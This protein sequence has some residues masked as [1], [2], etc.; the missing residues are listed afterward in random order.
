MKTLKSSVS[1][2][3]PLLMLTFIAC[4]DNGGSSSGSGTGT[5]SL[6]L[7]DN[8][9]QGC[10]AVYVTIDDVQVH[11][12]GGWQSLK[13]TSPHKTHNLLELQNGVREELG[14]AELAEG[15]YTQMRL[16]IGDT[17]MMVIFLQITSLMKTMSIMS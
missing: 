4:G 17:L 14:I 2:I 9:I 6:S 12:E 11:A 3:L 13:R 10:K 7:A 8:T 1:I 16:I 5:L 15:D